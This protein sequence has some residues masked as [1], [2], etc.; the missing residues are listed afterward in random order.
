MNA[1][2]SSTTPTSHL[3]TEDSLIYPSFLLDI[4][5]CC[6]GVGGLGAGRGGRERELKC[7]DKSKRQIWVYSKTEGLNLANDPNH[8]DHLDST[9]LPFSW[10]NE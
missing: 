1:T 9:Q 5:E 6:Y 10:Y 4:L 2:K 8:K 7:I 3:S